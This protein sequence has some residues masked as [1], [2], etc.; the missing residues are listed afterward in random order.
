MLMFFV[1]VNKWFGGVYIMRRIGV[2]S[3]ILL[4]LMVCCVGCG[5]S[6]RQEAYEAGMQQAS[7]K[8]QRKEVET[9]DENNL[10]NN[11]GVKVAEE[12]DKA[13]AQ[14]PHGNVSSSQEYNETEVIYVVDTLNNRL[15]KHNS[16]CSLLGAEDGRAT[17][18]NWYGTPEEA[19]AK[20]YTKCPECIIKLY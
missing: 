8:I 15:H 20:G 17:L 1:E 2:M 5:K 14:N 10:E 6:K 7:G 19:E 11:L 9:L 13:R 12:K 3:V 4:L 16:G 18:E